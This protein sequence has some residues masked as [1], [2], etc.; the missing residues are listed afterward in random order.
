MPPMKF[1]PKLGVVLPKI[2]NHSLCVSKE[3]IRNKRFSKK[4]K[5]PFYIFPLF[6]VG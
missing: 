2:A 5:Y 3:P 6:I 1:V 4:I